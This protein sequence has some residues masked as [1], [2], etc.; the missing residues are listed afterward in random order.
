MRR[1]PVYFLVDVSE[2]MIGEP[3]LHVEEGIRDIITALKTDPNALETVHISI[4][5]FAGK[6]KTLV[7]LQDIVTFYP[8][9]FPIGGG[10]SLGNGFYHLMNELESNVVP[11]S[12]T[13]KG[14]WKPL[15]FLLTDGC[16]TDDTSTA[17]ER[18]LKT[19]K[20][21]CNL[22]CISFGANTDQLLLSKLTDNLLQ[23]D[24]TDP[25][26][27]KRFFAWISAS[28]RTS[29]ERVDSGEE[30]NIEMQGNED[31]TVVDLRKLSKQTID[32]NYVVLTG[33]C[34]TTQRPYLM[35]YQKVYIDSE[36]ETLDLQT[37]QY[38][39]IGGFQ[40]DNSYFELSE[41][42]NERISINTDEL[43]GAPSCP[44]CGN[45]FAF[46]VCSCGGLHC[47]GNNRVNTCPWCKIEAEYGFGDG[48]GFNVTR[49]LG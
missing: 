8:P 11:N 7:P 32:D 21:R 48:N 1:L 22:I 18:W 30:F 45:Q 31:L 28:I 5:V 42:H 17:I 46:A 20:S 2:S 23:F 24:N 12:S 49:S 36:I 4:V 38:Q 15:V 6:A 34:Q 44:C 27:Y 9:K 13:R 47:I 33:K 19:W 29:S 25:A 43:I 16:P 10:T 37:K 39:L 35:K 41:K 40:V 14:D 3:I 26:A